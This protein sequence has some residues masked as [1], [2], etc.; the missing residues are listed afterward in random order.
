MKRTISVLIAA[1]C[2]MCTLPALADSAPAV[3]RVEDQAGH[4]IYLLGV[5]HIG[6]KD[7][8]PLGD[9]FEIAWRD[10][11][12]LAVEMDGT[13]LET[14][15]SQMLKY[16]MATTF[17]DGDSAKNHLSPEAYSLGLKELGQP[18]YVLRITR[19]YLWASLAESML[20]DALGYTADWGVDGTLVRRAHEEGKPVLEMEGIDAQLAM[21]REIPDSVSE[22]IML[23]ILQDQDVG[24]E[25]ITAMMDA[26]TRGDADAL[27]QWIETDMENY[28]EELADVFHQYNDVMFHARNDAFTR[29]AEEYLQDGTT[30][31]I[32]IGAAH[33]LGADGLVNQLREAGY[34]VTEINH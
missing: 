6:R 30:V 10:A 21:L 2:L 27:A 24:K 4:H 13:V 20:Y 7:M 9:G 28:P 25:S 8:Y 12:A 3:Y 32:A 23:S 16:A 33:I 14:D 34:T 1:V 29:Q 17:S 5:V 11:E 19:P 18:E 31:L 15:A 22:T 26:Y